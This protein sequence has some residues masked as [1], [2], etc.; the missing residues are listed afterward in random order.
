MKL[1]SATTFGPTDNLTPLKQVPILIKHKDR[2][3]CI[4]QPRKNPNKLAY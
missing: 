2:L 3:D 1:L 4:N